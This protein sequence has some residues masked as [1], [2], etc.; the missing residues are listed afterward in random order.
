MSRMSKRVVGRVIDMGYHRNGVSGEG[1]WTIIFEGA[2]GSDVAG[3]V[4]VATYFGDDD[5]V[6]R[7][8]VLRVKSL[9]YGDANDGMRGDAFHDE[10]KALAENY[11]WPHEQPEPTVNRRAAI[12]HTKAKWTAP[13]G[14]EVDR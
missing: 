7:T 13:D 12:E 11:V 9:A 2:D 3:E 14:P 4:F 6:I 10:L 1:F 5:D 8:A